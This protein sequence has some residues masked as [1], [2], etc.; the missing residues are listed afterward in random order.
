M[1]LSVWANSPS[2]AWA[3][4]AIGMLFHFDGS[5]WTENKVGNNYFYSSITGLFNSRVYTIGYREDW[6]PP[7]DSSSYYL[8]P[9]H[10]L[11][12]GWNA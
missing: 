12:S 3:A 9:T 10:R 4:G 6:T 11:C 5:Q 1:L 7:N 2:D 8:F